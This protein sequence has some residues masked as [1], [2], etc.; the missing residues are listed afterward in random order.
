MEYFTLERPQL[1][2]HA[3]LNNGT[4]ACGVN[5]LDYPPHFSGNFWVASCEYLAS[6]TPLNMTSNNLGY[7]DAEMWIGQRYRN[8]RF[9]SVFQQ[10]VEGHVGLYRHWIQPDEYLVPEDSK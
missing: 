10:Q 6:L 3:I 2:L 4:A 5:F 7:T 9:L 8:S 1:C